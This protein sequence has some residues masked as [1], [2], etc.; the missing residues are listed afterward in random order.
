MKRVLFTTNEAVANISGAMEA[1]TI[2]KNGQSFKSRMSRAGLIV[3]MLLFMSVLSVNAQDVKEGVKFKGGVIAGL[4]FTHGG[5]LGDLLNWYNNI[6]QDHYAKTKTGFQIGYFI[7][8][9][10]KNPDWGVQWG[11]S[12]MRLGLEQGYTGRNPWTQELSRNSALFYVIGSIPNFCKSSTV[13][14]VTS[15]LCH[16]LFIFTIFT[17]ERK[18]RKSA[19]EYFLLSS[20]FLSRFRMT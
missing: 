3:V 9:P 18:S 19:G 8:K 4:N 5:Y 13:L 14:R 20:C 12:F 15:A 1:D 2:I 16:V 11:S 10:F 17:S 6:D 7:D